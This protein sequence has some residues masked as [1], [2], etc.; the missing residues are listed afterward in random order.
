ML[1][2]YLN[3]R[4]KFSVFFKEKQNVICFSYLFKITVKIKLYNRKKLLVNYKKKIY[5]NKKSYKKKQKKTTDGTSL[6][7][8]IIL[9][10]CYLYYFFKLCVTL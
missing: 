2:I 8:K 10:T 7:K 3:F 5:I 9:K 1:V 6:S 4:K